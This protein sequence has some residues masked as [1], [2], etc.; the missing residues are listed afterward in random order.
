MAK[1]EKKTV[2]PYKDVKELNWEETE[3]PNEDPG[4]EFDPG[5]K[6]DLAKEVLGDVL[7]RA[8][9]KVDPDIRRDN[10]V[11]DW[12]ITDSHCTFVFRDG[13]KVTV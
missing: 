4:I 7:I 6:V 1:K 3:K 10:S 9:M 11:W 13:R 2:E 8:L 12:A 5:L